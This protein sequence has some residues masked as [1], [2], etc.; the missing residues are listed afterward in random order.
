M[1]GLA[2]AYDRDGPWRTV[3]WAA[4]AFAGGLAA[5]VG[6][7]A[8]TASLIAGFGVGKP[9]ALGIAVVVGGGL[10]PA[11]F[12][13]PAVRGVGDARS[14]LLAAV[15]VAAVTT[16]L[17]WFWTALPAGW[18]GRFGALPAGAAVAY[19]V[20]LLAAFG[21]GLAAWPGTDRESRTER[22][23]ADTLG[24]VES[25]VASREGEGS[26]VGASAT[27]GDG[28]EPESDLTFFDDEES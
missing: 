2:D 7:V 9:R 11:G 20:G 1:T 16:G 3:A 6:V 28:G 17:A 26:D 27:V 15:A 24:G 10:L 23:S 25:V 22:G 8:A 19:A 12:L 21:A 14:H 4:L 18:T 13:A 5:A